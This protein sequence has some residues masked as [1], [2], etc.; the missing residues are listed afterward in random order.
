[1]KERERKKHSVNFV[2]IEH[3]CTLFSYKE[4]LMAEDAQT[5][6]LSVIQNVL[7]IFMIF[8]RIFYPNY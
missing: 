5:M 8:S 6:L 7:E 4:F 1:M 2:N 3:C